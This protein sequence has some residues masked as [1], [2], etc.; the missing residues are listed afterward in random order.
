M[1]RLIVAGHLCVD[2]VP[3]SITFP[4]EPGR[5]STIGPLSM[6]L[7][8]SVANTGSAL[9]A[10]GHEVVSTSRVGDDDLGR[11]ASSMLAASG[12]GGTPVVTAG[13]HTS[14]SIVLE[15][16]G[17]DR[18]FWHHVGANAAFDGTESDL[19]ADIVHLGYPSLLPGMLQR[20]AAGLRAFLTRA[21]G[22]GATTSL[23]LAVVDASDTTKWAR[24][25]P[26]VMPLVDIVTPS[27]DDLR[28]ALAMPGAS[29]GD[30]VELLIGWGAGVAAVSD[31]P[32]GVRLGA[33][34]AARLS[35]AGSVL[36][37]LASSWA[38][39][40]V[41]QPAIPVHRRATTNGAGDAATAGLLSGILIGASPGAA[42]STAVR[43]AARII[44]G[45]PITPASSA[46][47]LES[48]L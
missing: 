35:A 36:G 20:D 48:V 18:S 22:V 46:D 47:R 16:Q 13:S 27:A 1:S 4:I 29:A 7:G 45:C 31:G 44:Q 28:S 32:N 38:G 21:R 43:T 8:G 42:A 9:A 2:L 24:V 11:F 15:P 17:S 23:D 25:L 3:Q 12:V 37:R 41:S 30:L 14:Y 34:D 40:R 10:L 19:D 26:D 6:R 5:L 33:G 39:A